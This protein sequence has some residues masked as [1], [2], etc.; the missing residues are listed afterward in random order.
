MIDI[1]SLHESFGRIVQTVC[2]CALPVALWACGVIWLHEHGIYLFRQFRGMFKSLHGV[3]A[4]IAIA[5]LVAWAGTKP[6]LNP[7]SPQGFNPGMQQLQQLGDGPASIEPDTGGDGATGTNETPVAVGEFVIESVTTNAVHD[8]SMPTNAVVCERWLRRG[9]ARDWFCIA[10]DLTW[11]FPFGTS[12]VRRLTV[13]SAGALLL[14]A[15]SRP[16]TNANER[17]LREQ[18]DPRND[19]PADSALLAPLRA[20]LGIVPLLNWNLAEGLESR[21]WASSTPSNTLLLTWQKVLLDRS[22][23]KPISFQVELT[24]GGRFRFAYDLVSATG[25]DLSTNVLAGA[26][27][28]DCRVTVAPPPGVVSVFDFHVENPVDTD[29]DGLN[30]AEEMLYG[31]NPELVDTDEDGL[32]DHDEV[33]RGTNPIDPDSDADGLSDGEEVAL[34][35]NPLVVDTDGDGLGDGLEAEVYGSDPLVT[36]SDGDGIGDAAEVTA[37]TSP[38]LA[39]TDGDGLND[40]AEQTAGTNPLLKDTD[41][42][43]ATDGDEVTAGSDP[44]ATDTDGDGLLDGQELNIGSSPLLWDT[45]GDGFTDPEEVLMGTDPASADTDD[46]GIPDRDEVDYL[47]VRETEWLDVPGGTVLMECLDQYDRYDGLAS[48]NLCAPVAIGGRTYDRVIVDLNGRIHLVPTN[49]VLTLDSSSGWNPDPA[50]IAPEADDII[51]AG[52]W[53][54]LVLRSHLGSNV[55]LA[56]CPS[57]GCTV[58]QYEN[59]GLYHSGGTNACLTFQIVIGGD[60]NF[61]IRVNYQEL[62]TN[63]YFYVTPTLG[64]INRGRLDFRNHS[65]SQRLIYAYNDV[66]G[67]SVPLSLGYRLGTGTDPKRADTDGDGL[68]DGDEFTEGTSPW[69]PDCDGDGLLDGDEIDAGTDPLDADSDNDGMPDGWEVKYGLNPH[70]ND[71]SH[72]ADTDGL[73]NLREYQLGTDP[74]KN[75]T[76][77]DGLNDN[78]EVNYGTS[79]ILADTDGD[80]LDD[81]AERYG[82]TSATNADTDNDGLPDGWETAHN[83]NATSSSGIYGASGDPDGD[84]LTNAEEYQLGTHPRNPDTDGDGI[85]DGEEL[86]FTKYA[87][88]ASEWASTTNGWT[89]V[90]ATDTDEYDGINYAYYDLTNGGLSIGREGIVDFIV[91]GNGIMFFNTD[92]HY[93]EWLIEYGP[94]SLSSYYLS[95]AALLLAPCWVEPELSNS[96]SSVSVLRRTS[97]VESFIAIQYEGLKL[98]DSG[99]NTVSVQTIL[100]FTNGVFRSSEFSYVDVSADSPNL[101]YAKTGVQNLVRKSRNEFSFQPV[102][103][104]PQYSIVRVA[105]TGT[106]PSKEDSDGDGLTDEEERLIGTDPSQPDT[107][108]DGMNDGWEHTYSFNP[109]VDN[110]TDNDPTNDYGY[111]RDNDGLTNGQECEWGTNPRSDDTDNDGVTDKDEIENGSDPTD[112]NDGGI[113]AS[114]VPVSFTFGDPS[115]SHSEK[116]RLVLEPVSESG[117][118]ETPPTK[119]WLNENYGECETKTAMLTKGWTYEIRLYHAGTNMED[120]SPDY[121]YLLSWSVPSCC[122]CV[123]NDPAGLICEDYTSSS[124]AGEGKIA[125]ILVLD[126]GFWADYNRTDGIDN[127]DKSKAY[128]GKQLRHWYN[129]DDDEGN[130]NESQGDIPAASSTPDCANNHVDGK[131]DVLDFTPVWIDMGAALNKI[132]EQL[133][134]SCTLTLAQEDGT[135]NLVWTSLTKDTVANFLKTSVGSCGSSLTANLAAADTVQLKKEEQELPEN[136]I[137]LMKGDRNKGVIL[138]EGRS[139]DGGSSISSVSPIILRIYEK[140]YSSDSTPLCELRLPLSLSSVERMYNVSNIRSA[141]GDSTQI[142]G[143]FGGNLPESNGTTVF[144]LHGFNVPAND[145]RAW[146]AE[147][148]KRLWQSGSNAR[149]CGVGWYGDYNLVSGKFNAMHYHRDAYNALQSASAFANLVGGTSGNKIVIAH[150]LGNMVASKAIKDGLVV[151]KYFMLDAAIPSEAFVATLQ[152]ENA[153][154]RRKYVPSSWRSYNSLSWAANWHRW[155]PEDDRGVLKWRGAF[156]DVPD[157]TDVYNYYSDGDE[158]FEEQSEVPT[159]YSRIFHWPTFKSSWPFV[160]TSGML[161]PATSAWQKQEVLKGIDL[162]VGTLDGGWGF[163]CW[164]EMVSISPPTFQ[165]KHYTAEEANAMVQNGSIVT[166]PVFDRGE[167]AMFSAII[168]ESDINHILAYNI[169]AVSSATGRIR[170]PSNSPVAGN[171]NLNTLDFKSNGWGRNHRWYLQRWL[172]S[173]MKDMAYFHVYKLFND[174][175][176]KGNLR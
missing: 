112:P 89:A 3:L 34:G 57:N 149:F 158:V 81:Y 103:I 134:K 101:V 50:D 7:P 155:F 68:A 118:G 26:F 43:G 5:A 65:R 127:S 56:E 170:L 132:A 27:C 83:L 87:T 15:D 76:D 23:D 130:T 162:L 147:M 146:F 78:V 163:H 42:D 77:G 107:D 104:N 51:V 55:R 29:G 138:I 48:T 119:S 62:V 63:E 108:G 16:A 109:L 164:Q 176:T 120:G 143:N 30:D 99:T 17:I 131:C 38:I 123:T 11:A 70:Q 113:P 95:D 73:T 114:R 28:G 117:P 71:A 4:A 25:A 59:V 125:K 88:S 18:L 139:P 82:S 12:A 33:V 35:T 75:D 49:G 44:F 20:R 52:F 79:P 96:V 116:Y 98:L 111:D 97:G 36:D 13:S 93:E 142:Q 157:M 14:H 46:D 92:R 10:N 175:C 84:G 166:H 171:F 100:A 39:D 110:A 47:A 124:F 64:V 121:D 37:G 24:P 144:F 31:T 115:G 94:Y 61:P 60:T 58:I 173:D 54:D 151:S 159:K 40:L 9:A 66:S 106:D 133:G 45:D 41:G 102:F 152:D 69:N 161:T 8:F 74:T 174:L 135:V 150:S 85:P 172:H 6:N 105:G 72:H 145:S 1:A 165:T 22:P 53:D 90:S 154:V 128:R 86:G 141:C 169:P 122:G 137:N 19:I 2:L 21:F 32:D 153:A 160:E 129:D 67:F 168:S 140:P 80:G 167:S 136:F 91:Q 156:A 126:G 148:F